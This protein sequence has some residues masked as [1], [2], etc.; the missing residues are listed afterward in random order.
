MVEG[1]QEWFWGKTLKE[2]SKDPLQWRE[3]IFLRIWFLTKSNSDN[4][5]TIP[6]NEIRLLLLSYCYRQ[7]NMFD[8][9]TLI[10]SS[11]FNWTILSNNAIYRLDCIWW[12]WGTSI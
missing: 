3:I 9:S 7:I 12:G 8:V 11:I 10:F 2:M 6:S 1:D 4:N 5:V